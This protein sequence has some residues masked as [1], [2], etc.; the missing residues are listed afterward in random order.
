MPT[1][2]NDNIQIHRL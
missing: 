2:Q 1:S